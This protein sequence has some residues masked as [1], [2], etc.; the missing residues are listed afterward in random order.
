M[1]HFRFIIAITLT[2]LHLPLQAQFY[3]T[4][5]DPGNK[6]WMQIE[7]DQ[8]RV[9]YPE[10]IDSLAHVYAR[11][12][13]RYKM[14]VSFSTGYY[15]GE[16][17]LHHKKMPVVL[18]PWNAFSN[19]SV[20]WAPKRM[21]LFT[22]PSPY[23]SEAIP[24]AR[25]LAIHESRHVTQMQ[26][27]LDRWFKPGNYIFGEM[28]NILTTLMWTGT[29]YMEGDAV[30]AETALTK[31]GRGRHADFLNY[32]MLAADQGIRK[33]WYQWKEISQRNY[34]PNYYALGYLTLGGFRYRW[35]RSDL[36]DQYYTMLRDKPFHC[37]GINDK[38]EQ[39]TGMKFKDIFSEIYDSIYERWKADAEKRKPYIQGTPVT[40]EPSI[41]T[42]Y[43]EPVFIG[44]R[45]FAIKRGFQDAG[46]LVEIFP[47]GKEKSIGPFARETSLLFP[48]SETGRIYWS[49]T[50]PDAR[51]TL[52]ATSKISYMEQEN[53]FRKKDMTTGGLLYNPV[54]S[55]EGQQIA[56]TE[57]T[58]QGRTRL[59][60]L[61]EK[62]GARE[63]V[64]PLPDSLQLIGAAWIGKRLYAS[65]LS[66]NGY[67]IYRFDD[68]W[69][70][71]LS[72]QPAVIQNLTSIGDNLIFTSD[73]S[74]ANEFYRLEPESGQVFQLT[75]T[76]YGVTQGT[77]SPD[78]KEFYYTAITLNGKR[79]Y[80]ISTDSLQNRPVDYG[81]LYSYPIAEA[82][83][84]QE[85]ELAR[86]NE[87]IDLKD[88]DIAISE[89]KRYRK[90]PHLFNI[91]S[92]T[93]VYVNVKNI[94]EVSYDKYYDLASLGMAGILQNQLS[95]AYGSFGYS[96][97]K[98][99]YHRDKWRHS[100]HFQF[101]YSGWYPVLEV[102]LDVNDRA[103]RQYRCADI[104]DGMNGN[105]DYT[106]HFSIFSQER[107]QPYVQTSIKAY[108][109]WN[110]SSGGWNKGVI[111][112]LSYTFSNDC[113]NS[114]KMTLMPEQVGINYIG[115][116][117]VDPGTGGKNS[118]THKLR[119]SARAYVMLP[120]PNSCVYP[121]WGIGA[122]LGVNMD[123]HRAD[124]FAHMGFA[125]LY[126]Y[127]PGFFRKQGFKFT[128]LHQRKFA[129]RNNKHR[130]GQATVNILPRGLANRPEI[131]SDLS[132]N[133]RDLLKLTADYAIPIYI[134]DINIWKSF[135]SIKRLEL[136]PHFD[137]ML[138]GKKKNLWSVG[139][140]FVFR[141]N[142]LVWIPWPC[143]L[144][145]RYDYNGGSLMKTYGGHPTLGRH[146]V[147]PLFSV[148]F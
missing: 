125:Y 6:R 54:P 142:T 13:E 50:V 49:E 20:A 17:I 120:I 83:S 64:I 32:Y 19:G 106:G 90:F 96:A 88:E 87:W 103:A 124:H 102:S 22:I 28:F 36:M 24:W 109:P 97:H 78:R 129:A 82:I 111:P 57:Y 67:G 127:V 11:N 147:G 59:V 140:D 105:V 47:N 145:V 68:G 76:R 79:L 40:A 128:A 137:F 71:L 34:A 143:S 15:P 99:P 16:K 5:D 69:N 60:L 63:K 146:F 118:Y 134:G 73:R 2:L 135:L 18:H 56:A 52:K 117:L 51:W 1:K 92:W 25:M 131:L 95:T 144:G 122:E 138:A 31:G 46:R 101:T 85:K 62:S 8:F 53:L 70:E 55:P 43:S 37:W 113:F 112:Q 48:S 26:F 74:G 86:K 141:L 126:G 98:D 132:Q 84:R 114:R 14:P 38:M 81:H 65:A 148:S 72:P 58:I 9:I 136:I 66:D 21:D 10:A 104:I 23:G 123:L 133:T 130:F 139:T 115:G 77:F 30:I 29:A 89:P 100:G 7:T 110:L 75:S 4:G 80:R 93:P 35:D 12:L 44:K 33:D 3:V 94:M 39:I 41:Y 27:G 121:R 42:D 116:F 107:K 119:L 45:L 91:H 108:I 61:N